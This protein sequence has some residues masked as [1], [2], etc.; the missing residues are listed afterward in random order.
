MHR[1]GFLSCGLLL[2]NISTAQV[3]RQENFDSLPNGNINGTNGFFTSATNWVV[4]QAG[5][6]GNPS[7]QSGSKFLTCNANSA[8]V[9]GNAIFSQWNSRNPG[10]DIL[11]LSVYVYA[12]S[13]NPSNRSLTTGITNS[14]SQW[15]AYTGY[16]TSGN[17]FFHGNDSAGIL[18]GP[19]G[20]RNSWHHLLTEFDT[21]GRKSYHWVNGLFVAEVASFPTTSPNSLGFTSI[22]T[23]ST[24]QPLA[25]FDTLE[26]KAVATGTINVSIL[27]SFLSGEFFPVNRPFKVETLVGSNVVES[28]V[29]GF[30]SAR[31]LEFTTQQSGTVK[32]RITPM[33][34]A[35]DPLPYLTRD[36]PSTLP[37]VGSLNLTTTM[38]SGD[39][40][41]DDAVDLLDYFILSDSYGLS[42]SEAGFN[43][44]ADFERDGSVDLLDYFILSDGYGLVGDAS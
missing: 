34:L 27:A 14:S 36:V 7:A 6:G 23:T 9:L 10:N 44:A 24:T 13:D 17:R 16:S 26:A 28:R 30:S 42:R 15:L 39:A 21:I 12:R 5:V 43:I 29:V 4:G 8:V 35:G 18:N 41:A 38:V 40:N 19:N 32:F 3:L 11:R 33:P 20:I 25:Y 37:R 2:A 1:A 22:P 31:K